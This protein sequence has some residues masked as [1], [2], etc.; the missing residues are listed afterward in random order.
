MDN[1]GFKI[2]QI[3][4]QIRTFCGYKFLDKDIAICYWIFLIMRLNSFL[5]K[6]RLISSS[7]KLNCLQFNK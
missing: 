5:L 2:F 4:Y 3:Q 1:D 7:I 6:F